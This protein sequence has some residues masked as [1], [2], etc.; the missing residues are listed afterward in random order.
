ME[1]NPKRRDMKLRPDEDDIQGMW[2][3]FK[4][5]IGI[6]IIVSLF[7]LIIGVK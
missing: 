4:Y 1:T 6:I 2:N 5:L 7:I 3:I